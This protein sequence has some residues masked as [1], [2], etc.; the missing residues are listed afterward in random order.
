ME[1]PSYLVK[2]G[3]AISDF[4]PEVFLRDA[5]LLDL[6]HKKPRELIDD[7]DLEA[8][9]E[10]AGLAVREGEFVILHTGF[11]TLHKH[12]NRL[13][14]HP[15]LSENG[16]Q[17]LEFKRVAGVGV[18]TPNLDHQTGK[19][20]PAHSTLMR[21]GALVLENLCNLENVGESRFRLIALPLKVKAAVS[22]V[23]A[24]AVLDETGLGS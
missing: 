12:R 15:A 6:S 1:A 20:L 21:K 23:R 3:K 9:E 11:A 5:V 13:A 14:A 24:V 8:A 4:G 18:D 7:E 19:D 22:P 16:A 2:G 10:G 17:Y